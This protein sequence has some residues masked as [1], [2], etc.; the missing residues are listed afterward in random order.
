MSTSEEFKSR[1][2]AFLRNIK[3]ARINLDHGYKI[4]FSSV[5]VHL[6]EAKFP[7]TG[8]YEDKFPGLYLFL[9]D[10][11][12]LMIGSLKFKLGYPLEI[13]EIQGAREHL[14]NLPQEFYKKTGQHFDVALVNA[15][16][17]EVTKHIDPP[18]D[19]RNPKVVQRKPSEP[20]VVFNPDLFA[21]LN[22]VQ[23]RRRLSYFCPKN[24][25]KRIELQHRQ[26]T[27]FGSFRIQETHFSKARRRLAK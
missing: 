10:P 8:F 26:P 2:S 1:L 27:L 6:L 9:K 20:K 14:S 23:A 7:Y 21:A 24:L 15:F 18:T 12:G 5:L 3:K 25:R 11:H 4:E 22:S 13:S 17:G 16:I 19:P